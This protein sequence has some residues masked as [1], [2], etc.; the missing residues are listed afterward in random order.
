MPTSASTSPSMI[1]SRTA[2]ASMCAARRTPTRSEGFYGVFKRGMRGIYQHCAEKH[3]HRYVSEFD[4]RYNNRVRLGVDDEQ[5][6]HNALRGVVGKRLCDCVAAIA[7]AD[8]SIIGTWK[9]DIQI[10][11]AEVQN[12]AKNG[13]DI[14]AEIV[15]MCPTQC[16]S[17]D[18]KAMK[19]NNAECSRCMHCIAKM[20]KALR[21]SRRKR[22]YHLYRK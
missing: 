6:T 16:M 11:Q 15:N 2:T 21:P 4:F 1:S 9:G 5:R 10:D 19:I 17:Y 7:R 12:Y 18:G 20:T 8:M 13:M 3:L 22:S 14:N